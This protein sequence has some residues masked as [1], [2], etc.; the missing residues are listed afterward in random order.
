MSLWLAALYVR[1]RDV[2]AAL[3]LLTQL[4]MFASPVAYPV[5]LVPQR[6]AW[7][8]NLNPMV[9]ILEG[10]QVAS[11]K[12]SPDPFV[13]GQK[14]ALSTD[15]DQWHGVFQQDGADLRRRDLTVEVAELLRSGVDDSLSH[16]LHTPASVSGKRV[17]EG[18]SIVGGDYE[19]ARQE[20]RR[21]P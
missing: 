2:G 13:I 9:G 19:I 8:Y 18:Q 21:Y 17:R 1:Y 5:S 14:R 10:F 4:W 20:Q 11:W 3:P 12:S 15:A 16:R 7:F 6:L